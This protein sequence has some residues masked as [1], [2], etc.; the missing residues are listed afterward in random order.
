MLINISIL[1]S[2]EHSSDGHF[3]TTDLQIVTTSTEKYFGASQ[4][5]NVTFL[6]I[7]GKRQWIKS[8]WSHFTLVV[9]SYL[10]KVTC[11]V[12]VLGSELEE[13]ENVED[14]WESDQA[15]DGGRSG[16]VGWDEVRVANADVTLDGNSKGRVDGAWN[17]I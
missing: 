11:L 5:M 10:C 13:S 15:T 4:E 12:E 8:V 16:H 2:T 14:E 17:K 7:Y 9:R 6:N 3:T 1:S